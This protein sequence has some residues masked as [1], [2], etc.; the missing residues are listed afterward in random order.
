[1]NTK[2]DLTSWLWAAPEAF[3]TV[4]VLFVDEAGQMSLADVLAV[5]QAAKTVVPPAAIVTRSG[6]SHVYLIKGDRVAET[7]VTL[8]GKVGEMQ[9]VTSGVKA[10]ERVALKPLEKLKDGSRVKV[11]GK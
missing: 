8:G 11:E 2:K 7:R 9:E 5:S 1:M 4:D 3:E 6:A 10:G